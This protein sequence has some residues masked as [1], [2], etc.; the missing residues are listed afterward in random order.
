[1]P[2]VLYKGTIIWVPIWTVAHSE[3]NYGETAD[4]FIPERWM[5]DHPA[6]H[7]PATGNRESAAPATF[8]N[9]G[10][11]PSH[12][13]SDDANSD[14]RLPASCQAGSA[15]ALNPSKLASKGLS[16]P[17]A[18]AF[19][20]G[21]RDCIGQALAKIEMQAVLATLVGKF[22]FDLAPEVGGIEGVKRRLVNHITLSPK[23]GMPVRIS[24]R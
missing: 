21:P 13:N 3:R 17:D 9:A 20:A 11:A 8:D 19:S 7:Q 12:Q 24:P 18:L 5:L 4:L 23:G 1:M 10:N 14:T 6:D 16:I 15:A 2:S 22:H